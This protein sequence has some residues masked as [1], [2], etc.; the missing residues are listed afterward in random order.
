MGGAEVNTTATGEAQ[1]TPD[2]LLEG[3]TYRVS[4]LLVESADS[5]LCRSLLHA[6]G[7]G[8]RLLYWCSTSVS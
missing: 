6:L 5:C 1:P 3:T 7:S 2:R 4:T 8:L